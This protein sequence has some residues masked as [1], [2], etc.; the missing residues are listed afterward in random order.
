MVVVTIQ[1]D[2]PSPVTCADDIGRD[3]EVNTTVTHA[4]HVAPAARE[5]CSIRIRY[6]HEHVGCHLVVELNVEVDTVEDTS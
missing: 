2:V 3:V 1:A 5:T 4:G 6:L